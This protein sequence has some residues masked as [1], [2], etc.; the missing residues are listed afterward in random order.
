MRRAFYLIFAFLTL[1]GASTLLFPA[2][3][4]HH[5]RYVGGVKVVS[6]TWRVTGRSHD[7][8]AVSWQIVLLNRTSEHLRV[9]GSLRFLGSSGEPLA[10]AVLNTELA[11]LQ[12]TLLTGG[13]AMPLKVA[14]G[15]ARLQATATSIHVWRL[16]ASA[17][18]AEQPNATR[19]SN[20]QA[21]PIIFYNA[22]TNCSENRADLTY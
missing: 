1:V 15:V 3:R 8:A 17:V 7:S 13:L 6:A 19:H 18:P 12:H 10:Y 9:K 22:T 11:G 21:F 5:S 16:R 20:G 4:G 2:V 14:D